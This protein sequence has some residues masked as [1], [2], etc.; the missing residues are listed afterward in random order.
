M[1]IKYRNNTFRTNDSPWC[2]DCDIYKY[3]D[4]NTCARLC[5]KK[6]S[7]GGFNITDDCEILEL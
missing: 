6:E 1:K 4:I 5:G 2:T 3:V 7:F